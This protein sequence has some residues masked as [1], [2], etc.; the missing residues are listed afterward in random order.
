MSSI[1]S[2]IG[3][4]TPKNQFSQGEILDFMVNAHQ[5]SSNDASRLKKLYNLSGIE[6][7]HSV[8]DDF[9]KK[10]GDFSFFG[11][12]N[13][14]MPF[15][16]T[17]KRS[18][19]YEVEAKKVCVAAFKNLQEKIPNLNVSTITHIITISCTGMYAPGLDI[20]MVELL[21]LNKS[22]ERTCIN[23]MGCYGAFNGLKIADYICR[24]DNNAKV[25]IVDAELCTLHFQRESTLE[26]WLANSLFSDGAAV[27]LVESEENASSKTGLRL[28]CFYNELISEAKDDMAWRIG[29]TGYEMRLS[30]QIA[31]YISKK[32]H[33][34]TSKVLEKGNLK[35]AEIHGLAVH[36]G[37]RRILEVCDEAFDST[38]DLS[39]S[40]E[41]LKN[42][43]NM[44]SATILFV[45]QLF[46]Q[47]YLPEQNI[48][49]FAFG[50]GL[51][52]ESLILQTI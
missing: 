8:L 1:I 17:K 33:D 39:K 22:I 49:S 19:V 7:R 21:E 14:L 13:G 48:M 37:G 5:L 23:F 42:Y 20:D 26:N 38:H 52:F 45:L 6:T 12:D 24:A 4:A 27:V 32:V 15:P 50:P 35:L 3:T 18:A 43:G 46:L 31:K 47:D 40:F 9:N 25:L 44:S 10:P 34:I 28:K 41:V 16:S 51:T 2:G 11:N 30:S 36:P 29:D